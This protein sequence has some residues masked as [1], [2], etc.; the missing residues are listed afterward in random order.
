MQTIKAHND[1]SHQKA[2]TRAHTFS[3]AHRYVKS[4]AVGDLIVDDCL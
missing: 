1:A 4:V 3:I 2:H